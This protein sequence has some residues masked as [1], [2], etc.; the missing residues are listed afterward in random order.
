MSLKAFA[1]I[2]EPPRRTI[3]FICFTAEENG[4]LGSLYYIQHQRWPKTIANINFDIGNVHG[5]TLDIVGLG[6]TEK[7][8]RNKIVRI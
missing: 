4:L 6:N 5:K 3:A 8:K 2:E 7:N 1:S